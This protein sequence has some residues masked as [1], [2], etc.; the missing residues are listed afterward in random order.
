VPL[1]VAALVHW[2]VRVIGVVPVTVSAMAVKI[3]PTPAV[4]V[5]LAPPMAASG[6]EIVAGE[7]SGYVHK[8]DL[9]WLS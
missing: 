7:E 2:Y 5:I 8:L 4:P 9:F 1:T 3:W 6:Q